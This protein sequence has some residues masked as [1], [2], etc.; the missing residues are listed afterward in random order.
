MV[1]SRSRIAIRPPHTVLF[2]RIGMQY[3]GCLTAVYQCFVNFH[4]LI[5][6]YII[7]V[8]K[9]NF[10]VPGMIALNKIYILNVKDVTISIYFGSYVPLLICNFVSHL[11]V[12]VISRSIETG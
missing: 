10:P 5:S 12:P 11:Y 3:G 7:C 8:A 6:P 9:Y 2:G 1:T 4:L